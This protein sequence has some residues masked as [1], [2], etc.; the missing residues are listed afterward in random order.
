MLA[1]GC[2][3]CVLKAD[4]DLTMLQQLSAL[5]TRHMRLRQVATHM[6]WPVLSVRVT[7]GGV[8]TGGLG[9]VQ[10]SG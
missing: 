7:G 5:P 1:A 8:C 9:G 10:K 3:S 6:W 2:A 4:R